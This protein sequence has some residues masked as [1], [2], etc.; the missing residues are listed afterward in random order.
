MFALYRIVFAPAW[1]PYLRGLLFTHKNG[2]FGAISVT[3][4]SCPALSLNW[5]VTYWIS[6]HT[7]PDR[8]RADTKT[9]PY[10]VSLFTHTQERWFRR[11]SVTE[12]SCAAWSRK[13][14][15]TYR[16]GG[17][18]IPDSF[19]AGTKTI[20]DRASHWLLFTHNNGD[21]GAISV[22]EGSWWASPISKLE[23]H[24]S[25]RCSHY[26]RQLFVATYKAIRYTSKIQLVAIINAAFWLVELLLG[27][28]L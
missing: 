3:V 8:F 28:M 26:I 27:H 14:G 2:D 15:V 10:R 13:C 22:T 9:I 6:V 12:R 17:H 18:N 7:I 4:R 21:F 20:P 1:K 23:S 25:N 24:K 16:V 11:V 5:R 19:C